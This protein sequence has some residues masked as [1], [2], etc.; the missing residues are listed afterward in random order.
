[1]KENHV[2]WMPRRF[3]GLRGVSWRFRAFGEAPDVHVEG[4][5]DDSKVGR[6]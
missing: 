5:E 6:F 2:K 1:M 4:N 3:S